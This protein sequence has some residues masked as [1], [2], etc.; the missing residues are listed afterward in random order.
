MIPNLVTEPQSTLHDR[1]LETGRL[2]GVVS[3]GVG[4]LFIWAFVFLF[5]PWLS[6]ISFMRPMISY[7][8]EN[9]IDATALYYT[10]IEQFAEADHMIR[11]LMTYPSSFQ[12][13]TEN[14]PD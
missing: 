2:K 1:K 9:N 8:E 5:V 14:G 12:S 4:I 13:G 3:L 6:S 10:E 7:I 11:H